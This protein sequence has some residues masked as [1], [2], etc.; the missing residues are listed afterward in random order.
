MTDAFD[1]FQKERRQ[2]DAA[3]R[4]RVKIAAAE[5]RKAG[6]AAAAAAKREAKAERAELR[7]QNRIAEAKRLTEKEAQE[8]IH[9]A[10]ISLHITAPLMR[11]M[12]E[13]ETPLLWT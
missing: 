1:Q 3:E 6:R 10:K 11:Q 13:N 12:L 8:F 5:Q 2:T 4:A 9:L 7:R